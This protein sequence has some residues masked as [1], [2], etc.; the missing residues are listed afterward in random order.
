LASA[1]T[2]AA[3]EFT[4]NITIKA[5][6]GLS[7]EEI[8]K[9]VRD[10]EVN[11]EADRKFEELAQIRNQADHLVHSTRKQVLE[12][13][14]KLSEDDKK[15]IEDAVSALEVA[16]RGEDKAE[17]EAKIQA[18]MEASKKLLE[19]AQQQAGAEQDDTGSNAKPEDDIVD[20]DF[21]EVDDNK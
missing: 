15:A 4:K 19:I 16:A 2:A 17:I 9:M 5:S 14:D 11:A 7:E 6:S 21:K 20:A 3:K 10:A 1:A 12:A 8:Q 13:G 18:L